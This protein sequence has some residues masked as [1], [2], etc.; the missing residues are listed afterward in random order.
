MFE[1]PGSSYLA[2]AARR[3]R[4]KW[5][6]RVVWRAR[7]R[8][9]WAVLRAIGGEY[10]REA[11]MVAVIVAGVMMI[12]SCSRPAPEN[13]GPSSPS[14]LYPKQSSGAPATGLFFFSEADTENE[15]DAKEKR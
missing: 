12:D 6:R 15:T 7:L 2:S 1:T 14:R 3:E 13:G 4:Q 10:W 9:V 5:V 11:G 8:G